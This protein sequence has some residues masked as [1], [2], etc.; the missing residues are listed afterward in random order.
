MLTVFFEELLLVKE[1]VCYERIRHTCYFYE[2][3]FK[4]LDT[5]NVTGMR[6]GRRKILGLRLSY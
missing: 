5:A 3:P 1:T 2:N 6:T 4:L